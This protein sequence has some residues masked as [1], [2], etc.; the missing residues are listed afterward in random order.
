MDRDAIYPKPLHELDLAA[1]AE[2]CANVA[3]NLSAD[4]KQSDTAH[5][6]RIEWV[7][8]RVNGSLDHGATEAEASLRN[9]MREFL[10]EVPTWMASGL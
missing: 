6:L 10:G 4:S 3:H 1:L 2:L 8:L 7:R 5:A 9:R